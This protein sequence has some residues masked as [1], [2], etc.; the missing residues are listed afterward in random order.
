MEVRESIDILYSKPFD[1]PMKYHLFLKEYHRHTPAG[2]P[3]YDPL[4]SA[5]QEY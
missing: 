1:R 4:K 2:H 5:I 3:D